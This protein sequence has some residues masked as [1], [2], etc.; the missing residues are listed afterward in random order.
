MKGCGDDNDDDD[1]NDDYDYEFR[2]CLYLFYFFKPKIGDSL[3]GH[4]NTVIDSLLTFYWAT[5]VH[6]KIFSHLHTIKRAFAICIDLRIFFPAFTFRYN[7]KR[8]K[9][10]NIFAKQTSLLVRSVFIFFYL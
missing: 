2:L 9:E 4:S 6:N 8:K 5:A 10:K 7:R 1:D 3:F